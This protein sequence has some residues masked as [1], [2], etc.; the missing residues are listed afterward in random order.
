MLVRHRVFVTLVSVSTLA[1]AML[2]AVVAGG[3]T[4]AA[5]P[6]TVKSL[7]PI[8][9]RLI[10]SELINRGNQAAVTPSLAGDDEGQGP[11][12]APQGVPSS[13][14][15]TGLAGHPANYFPAS[16]AGCSTNFGS[17]TKVNQ[18]CLNLTDPDLQGR[19]QANNETSIA[20][21]PMSPGHLVASD[22]DYVRGDGTCGSSYST[23]S[24]AT[25][26][27]STVPNSF[28]RGIAGH[29]RQYWQA[30]GDTSVAWD[31]KGNAYLSCQLFNRGTVAS[32][33]PDQSSAFVVFRSTANNGASWNFPGRYVLPFS[34]DPTASGAPAFLDKQLMTVDNHVGSPFQDRIYVSWTEFAANGTA[35]IYE[36]HSRDFGESFSNKVLVSATSAVCTNTFDI[37]TPNGACNENQFS[38]PFTGP[39]GALYVT[40]ANFNNQATSGDNNHYQMMLA[41]STDGGSSFSAPVKVSDYYDLPDCDPYQGAGADPG[42]ACVPEKGSTSNSVFRATN[43]PSGAVDPTNANR[44]IV[45][46]GS[47]INAVSQESNGCVPKGFSGDGNPLYKG[48]KTVGACNNKIL[49][50]T[51][52]D[53]GA[54]FSGTSVNPRREPMVTQ[55]PGQV[56]TD[57]WWQW[58]AISNTG[59]LAVSYYDRQYANNEITGYSDF[60]LSGSQ[61]MVN[62]GQV[63]VTTSSMPPPTEFPGA[64]G[65]GQFWGDYTG[66]SAVTNQAHPLWSDTR[67]TDIF[68]CPGSATGPT[69]PPQL[70]SATENTGLAANDE[71]IYTAAVAIPAS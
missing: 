46:F 23:N 20:Q 58:A 1:V 28:T 15:T 68:L 9:K 12:G 60:S 19:G 33:N 54:T 38:Q 4:A 32:A 36:S 48:V 70:C 39:D 42:R 56:G 65:A 8:Q 71:E 35:Y 40:Y 21:D 24:G 49:I 45:T 27:N 62:F 59:R 30:S 61:D 16:S 6:F 10:S 51:S 53:A 2:P 52:T 44:V 55:A 31:T 3:G 63:R 64:S 37:D 7:N 17:N 34:F 41:K 57:Q 66:L 29:A 14:A 22:N 13:F 43:Y 18:N 26:T 69:H 11:D 67:N 5:A 47:Y 50:S 25:W